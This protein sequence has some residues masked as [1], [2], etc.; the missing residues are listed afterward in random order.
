[1]RGRILVLG[2]VL[3]ASAATGLMPVAAASTDS[4][5]DSAF[6][7]DRFLLSCTGAM[8]T[9][10]RAVADRSD[11]ARQIIAGAM[12]DL[13]ALRVHGFGLG[14][15]PIVVLTAGVIG[16]GT[17]TVDALTRVAEPPAARPPT[18]GTI[19]EGSIDRQSGATR[20]VVRSAPDAARVLIAMSLDCA[21]E[22]APH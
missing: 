19:V 16:F 8:A 14:S 20:I 1:M 2:A 13:E 17:A 21:F 22:P 7:G 6:A 10:G 18:N 12:V 9:D 5:D 15:S 4:I 11:P 3:I